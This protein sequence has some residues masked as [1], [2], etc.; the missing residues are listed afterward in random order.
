M[1]VT[2]I[3]LGRDLPRYAR[4]SVR[5]AKE[6][7]G[8]NVHVVGNAPLEGNLRGTGVAFTAVEDFYCRELFEQASKQLSAPEQFRHGFW[9]RTLERF[10]VLHQF[11]TVSRQSEVLHAELDQILFG[12]DHL[13]NALRTGPRS[14]VFFPF[15]NE[16]A[17]IASIF[18]CND[19]A[20]LES[21]LN[22]AAVG[23]SFTN[24]MALLA[25]W[26]LAN[27]NK[28]HGLPTMATYLQ[29]SA[30]PL[31]LRCVELSVPEVGGIVDAA[32]IGQWAAG[33]DPRNVTLPKL[34]R[35]KFA[36]APESALLTSN[37]LSKLELEW[38]RET[39]SL[40]CRHPETMPVRLFN[41]HIHS[42]IHPWINRRDPELTKLISW[43]N[44]EGSRRVPGTLGRQVTYFASDRIIPAARHPKRAV[45]AVRRRAN[46]RLNRRPS[47]APFISGDTFRA[48]ADA[49]WEGTGPAI[50]WRRLQPGSL[51][52]CESDKVADFDEVVL[53]HLD[54]PVTLALGNSDQNH[55][56]SIRELMRH[57][58]VSRVFAQNLLQGA[59]GLEVLPIGLE[60][61]WRTNHG[62]IRGFAS[63]GRERWRRESRVMWTF[64]VGTNPSE[65]SRA[66]ASLR[67]CQMATA[68][69]PISPSRHRAALRTFSFVASPPGNGLDTHRTWEAMYLGC[70]P[71]VL[72]SFMTE[73]YAELGLPVW[74]IDSFDELQAVGEREL[75]QRYSILRPQFDSKVLWFDYWRQRMKDSG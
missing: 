40:S 20:S 43:V 70:V 75:E 25:K 68:L 44:T 2:F 57:G 15:H 37:Q 38:D 46:E 11:M 1:E 65:R 61:A 48:C 64:S 59:P 19:T 58:N 32:Q 14:G 33:I 21:L 45:T 42:K 62:M 27:P 69:G 8:A 49:I 41:L 73:R 23:E 74:V 34:L 16:Q 13:V 5:L 63:R 67:Q 72:R 60:N 35:S 47:S 4:S 3:Y 51:I 6:T 28:A 24:E 54:V 10:F 66:A 55:D 26:A 17:A 36:D 18:Y 9:Y 71:I 31:P 30:R 7:S 22:Q 56:A 50:D 39:R 53:S 12:V 52:F 29:E